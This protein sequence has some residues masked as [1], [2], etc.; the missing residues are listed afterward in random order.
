MS[1]PTAPSEGVL[2][3]LAAWVERRFRQAQA[4]VRSNQNYLLAQGRIWLGRAVF[5][6]FGIIVGLAAVGFALM[7]DHAAHFFATAAGRHPWLPFVVAPL[8]G[9]GLLWVTR[10]WFPGSQGSGIPQVIAEMKRATD[11]PWRPLISLRIAVG[12]IMVGV[13]AVGSGFSFGREGP[14]VQV[15]AC[16]MAAAGRFL[17][18][19]LRI[20]RAHLLVAGGAAGIAAAFN[21]PLAGIVFAI[22]ELS[23]SIE[24]RMS[25]VVITAIVLAGV[26]AQHFLGSDN[27]FGRVVVFGD[28][29]ELAY[30]IFV[31][32]LV[33][34]ITGGLFARLL[35]TSALGWKGRLADWRAAHPYG[36]VAFCG[37]LVAALGHV[38][39]GVTWGSGFEQTHMLLSGQADMP[40]YFGPA[41]FV[42]TVVSYL[43][44]LPGGIFAPSLAIGAGVGQNLQP[45][46]GGHAFPT[47]VVVLCMVGFLAAATQAPITAFVIVM[48]MVDGYPLVIGLM[49][50]ALIASAVSRLVSRP[51]YSSLAEHMV[52]QQQ[53]PPAAT[54]A[55]ISEPPAETPK[56]SAG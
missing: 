14:T 21:A 54:Q 45:L 22:E 23:R 47:T 33:T 3:R 10:N 34:G 39:G 43:S 20:Q 31:C 9:A 7:T 48:E 52:R 41:K 53:P 28:S 35:L 40:W 15:G 4:Y 25:G 46:L 19:T 38:T 2:I 30:A 27:Y 12:K 11:R 5:W 36:F 42:A 37:L 49:A 17:P 55:A 8:A 1:E 44:G 6:S 16:L 51:L 13:A 29:A 26:I 56:T 50:T 24:S 18:T 32:A